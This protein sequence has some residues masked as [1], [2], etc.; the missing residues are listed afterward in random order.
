MTFS[1]MVTKAVEQIWSR[2][3]RGKFNFKKYYLQDRA[4]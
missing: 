2:E 4:I 3:S 1:E